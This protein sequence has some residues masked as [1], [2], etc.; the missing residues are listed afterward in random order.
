MRIVDLTH[1]LSIHTPGWVGYPSPK[2]WYFQRFATQGIVSQ[3]M[4]LPLHTGTHFDG[5]MH[6]VSGGRDLASLPIEHL[7]R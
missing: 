2:L 5:E 6:I 3:W 1:P 4:E 7:C